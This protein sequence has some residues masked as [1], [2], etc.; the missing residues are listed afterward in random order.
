MSGIFGIITKGAEEPKSRVHLT[1]PPKIKPLPCV[2]EAWQLHLLGFVWKTID[3]Y[4]AKV[5]L[6]EKVLDFD[7]LGG[8]G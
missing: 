4:I 5:N 1:K 7:Q 8:P 6:I 2:A 3:D